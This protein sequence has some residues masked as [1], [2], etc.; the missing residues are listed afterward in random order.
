MQEHFNNVLKQIS[1]SKS[2]KYQ[3]I[4]IAKLWPKNFKSIYLVLKFP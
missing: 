2:A 1:L 3:K 4:Q